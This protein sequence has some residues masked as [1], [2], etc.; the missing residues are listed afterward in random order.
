MVEV[1]SVVLLRVIHY[2]TIQVQMD[3]NF[4]LILTIPLSSVDLRSASVVALNVGNKTTIDVSNA[5]LV[6]IILKK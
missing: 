4:H 6:R 2:L 1:V 5:R 3:A